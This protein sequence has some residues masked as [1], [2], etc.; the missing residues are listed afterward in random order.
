[1]G[2]T[3]CQLT[4]MYMITIGIEQAFTLIHANRKKPKRIE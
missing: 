1:M 2:K 4:V 3:F